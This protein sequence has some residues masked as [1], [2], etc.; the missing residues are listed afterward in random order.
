M[1]EPVISFEK[2]IVVV[3]N[4]YKDYKDY[5][6]PSTR[7]TIISILLWIQNLSSILMAGDRSKIILQCKKIINLLKKLSDQYDIENKIAQ[8]KTFNLLYAHKQS[9][10]LGQFSQ[11]ETDKLYKYSKALNKFVSH[12]LGCE[13]P[14]SNIMIFIMNHYY[15]LD[16][17]YKKNV[18]DLEV[19]CLS[20]NIEL[21]KMRFSSKP[22]KKHILYCN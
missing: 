17:T 22:N 6:R 5:L 1:T 14:T 4:F 19:K 3:E 15:D 7:D 21:L 9:G 11:Q 2:N 8:D 18:N 20:L 16:S 12:F 13:K 10:T